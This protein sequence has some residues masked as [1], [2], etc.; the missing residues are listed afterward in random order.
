V[1][2]DTEKEIEE[3][4]KELAA[5]HSKIVKAMKQVFICTYPCD[6]QMLYMNLFGIQYIVANHKYFYN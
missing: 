4:N 5:C 1:L 3:Y 6:T 2:S